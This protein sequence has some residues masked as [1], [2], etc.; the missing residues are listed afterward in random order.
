MAEHRYKFPATELR[1]DDAVSRHFPA[2]WQARG[3]SSLAV[4][5][6]VFLGG[7][8]LVTQKFGWPPLLDRQKSAL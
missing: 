5:V 6:P 3:F 8:G 4:A 2:A 1:G 7:F